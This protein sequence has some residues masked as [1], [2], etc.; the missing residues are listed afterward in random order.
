MPSKLVAEALGTFALCF[1]GAGAICMAT[2]QDA[3]YAGLVGVAIAHGIALSIG[4]SAT[5]NVS[6]GHVNPAV[7][8]AMLLTGRIKAPDAIQ[9]IIAQCAGATVAGILVLA[10]F[11]GLTTPAPTGSTGESVINACGLGT[12]FY[13]APITMGKAILI[14]AGLTFMLVFA[15]FGTAVDP[16]APKIGGFGIGLTICADIL[17]GG[18]LTGAA[19]NPAR[20]FGPGIVATL[21]GNLPQFWSQHLVY[22][23]GP[24]LGGAVAAI[25][26]DKMIMEKRA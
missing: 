26:Y 2:Y 11:G 25:I 23:I 1:L 4:V 21:S 14:E 20:T 10:I 13:A 12:P 9:Y 6:G 17:L 19:M 5:M 22:W 7:T 3:G 24:I 16:R 8:V 15:I 18:P